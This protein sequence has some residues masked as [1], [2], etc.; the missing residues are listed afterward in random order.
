MASDIASSS[1]AVKSVGEISPWA[2]RERC[3]SRD[4]G[5]SRLPMGSARK[6][7][8]SRV[9]TPARTFIPARLAAKHPAGNGIELFDQMG[10]ARFGC[11]NQRRIERAIR[12]DRARLVLAWKI[13]RQSR[14]KLFG[15][16]RIGQ[17]H[18][19]DVLH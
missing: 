18:L 19:D 4:P 8:L 7:G 10:V 14:N 9:T 3:S 5:R 15:L 1:A 12:P 2:Q 16:S 13:A 17:Q 6:G 11:C